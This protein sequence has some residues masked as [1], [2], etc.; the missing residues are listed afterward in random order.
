M[1]YSRH[2]LGSK[3]QHKTIP[4]HTCTVGFKVST[5]KLWTVEKWSSLKQ[6]TFFLQSIQSEKHLRFW[7][8]NIAYLLLF[9]VLSNHYVY[10]VF[11]DSQQGIN[12]L[13]FFILHLKSLCGA[14]VQM[15]VKAYLHCIY[16]KVKTKIQGKMSYSKIKMC[17]CVDINMVAI[18]ILLCSLKHVSLVWNFET[19]L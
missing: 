3:H 9:V 14:Q 5:K 2:N 1:D 7:K 13:A 16:C 11:L 10:V 12:D 17:M 15:N 6:F 19:L 18:L 4:S 8:Q